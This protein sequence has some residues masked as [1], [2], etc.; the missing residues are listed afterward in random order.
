MK[1]IFVTTIIL[2]VVLGTLL[3]YTTENTKE[4][5]S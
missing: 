3:Y 4:A 5:L 1:G 2:G